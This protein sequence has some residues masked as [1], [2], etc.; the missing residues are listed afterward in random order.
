MWTERFG[1]KRRSFAE[2]E[3][4]EEEEA[5]CGHTML[6]TSGVTEPLSAPLVKNE[7]T[8]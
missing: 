3:E 8:S 1:L 5:D 6:N 7:R 4:E 2:A